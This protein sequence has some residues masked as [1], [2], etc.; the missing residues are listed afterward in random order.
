M[1]IA[2]PMDTEGAG[3]LFGVKN[4]EW[5]CSMEKWKRVLLTAAGL[6]FLVSFS[7]TGF[8]ADEMTSTAFKGVKVNK[9]TVKFSKEGGKKMLT[10]SDDF[11]V[12]D[13]PDPHWQVVD[14]KGNVYLLQ[15]YMVKDNKYNK[16]ITVPAYVADIKKVQSWCSFAEALLGEAEFKSPMK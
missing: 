6:V 7:Q 3:L 8:S 16:T 11:V 12:P 2:L 10:L 1:D 15:K 5:R 4:F 13:T 14:S 9:G